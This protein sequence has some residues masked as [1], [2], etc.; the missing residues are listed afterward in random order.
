[1]HT[2]DK[3]RVGGPWG[4]VLVL[5]CLAWGA[6]ARGESL[7]CKVLQHD[8]HLDSLRVGD[9][10]AHVLAL[11]SRKGVAVLKGG[12]VVDFAT[13]GTADLV[14][15]KGTVTGYAM[16]TY[17]D[18][19][20]ALSIVEGRTDRGSVHLTGAFTRGT[21]RLEGIKG[22]MAISGNSRMPFDEERETIENVHYD[23]TATYTLSPQ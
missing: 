4:V 15:G 20:T 5:L 19:S 17:Q 12:E 21:G 18:G 22:T 13:W 8:V 3:R 1:M 9:A 16:L 10:E 6:P 23:L 7:T 11:F 14:S 2:V